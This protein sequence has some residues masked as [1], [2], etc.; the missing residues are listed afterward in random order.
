MT[1]L[2]WRFIADRSGAAA[3]EYAL[4]ATLIGIA[5]IVAARSLG[6]S[7]AGVFNNIASQLN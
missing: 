6:I 5:V 2:A 4:V 7:I 3:I 1:E